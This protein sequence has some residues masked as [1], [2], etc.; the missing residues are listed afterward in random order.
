MTGTR[1]LPAWTSHRHS[2]CTR[3][4][5]VLRRYLVSSII[6]PGRANAVADSTYSV[7]QQVGR[8]VIQLVPRRRVQTY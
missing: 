6:F 8:I 5:S 4:Y 1:L 7:Q 3:Y 2:A